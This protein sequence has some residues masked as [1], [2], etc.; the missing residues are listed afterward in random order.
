MGTGAPL[1]VHASSTTLISSLLSSYEQSTSQ[2]KDLKA[3]ASGVVL[4]YSGQVKTAEL[5]H[6]ELLGDRNTHP[7]L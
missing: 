1:K 5:P 4:G 3:G 7:S 2:Q 6:T